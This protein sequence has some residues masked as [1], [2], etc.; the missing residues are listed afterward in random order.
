MTLLYPPPS[1]AIVA[2]RS[3]YIIGH[4]VPFLPRPYQF[5]L[6]KTD[7]WFPP[8]RGRGECSVGTLF[9][10]G[11]DSYNLSGKHRFGAIISDA[12]R[13]KYG[14]G[15]GWEASTTSPKY[16]E[17]CRVLLA[18]RH[19][20]AFD[21]GGRLSVFGRRIAAREAYAEGTCRQSFAEFSF[22]S[23]AMTRAQRIVETRKRSERERRIIIVESCC[24]LKQLRR[25]KV[26]R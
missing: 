23:F 5:V 16:E 4:G 15:T 9:R 2:V 19:S 13:G 24:A 11:H 12:T 3:R 10:N 21:V 22:F 20:R 6:P 26:L 14:R 1:R 17:T 18:A 25:S 7:R 8:E